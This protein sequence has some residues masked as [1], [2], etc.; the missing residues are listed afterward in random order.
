MR[1]KIIYGLIGLILSFSISAATP[2]VQTGTVSTYVPRTGMT[3]INNTQ[4]Q[5][6]ANTI[7]RQVIRR[8][9]LG[10]IL[11]EGQSI[12]FNFKKELGQ[13]PQIS[14]VWILSN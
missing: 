1:M 4:Y 3:I 12:G 8:G 6:N 2:Y 13:V 14:E 7:C 5:V 10:P 9:E 11:S